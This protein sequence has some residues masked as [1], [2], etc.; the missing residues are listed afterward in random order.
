VL[1]S[2]LV[3]EDHRWF[4]LGHNFISVVLPR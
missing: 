2:V 1:P 3:L 4:L